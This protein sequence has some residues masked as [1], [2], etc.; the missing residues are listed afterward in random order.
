MDGVVERVAKRKRILAFGAAGLAGSAAAGFVA[1]S[2]LRAAWSR[3]AAPRQP[4]PKAHPMG[5]KVELSQNFTKPIN[6]DF[7]ELMVDMCND[8]ASRYSNARRRVF[9]PGVLAKTDEAVKR[10]LPSDLFDQ[11]LFVE[12]S[13]DDGWCFACV[14]RKQNHIWVYDSRGRGRLVSWISS[15]RGRNLF[16]G[17]QITTAIDGD[18]NPNK[19]D[20][21]GVHVCARMYEFAACESLGTVLLPWDETRAWIDDAAPSRIFDWLRGLPLWQPGIDI[22]PPPFELCVPE[23]LAYLPGSVI[24][25][26]IDTQLEKHSTEDISVYG[27][28]ALRGLYR[29]GFKSGRRSACVIRSNQ[30]WG[31][32]IIDNSNGAKLATWIGVNGLTVAE[33]KEWVTDLQNGLVPGNPGRQPRSESTA[34]EWTIEQDRDTTGLS[35]YGHTAT[36]VLVCAW[37]TNL[38]LGRRLDI[39]TKV[40]NRLNLNLLG[41]WFNWIKGRGRG[42]IPFTNASSNGS[43]SVI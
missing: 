27:P 24:Q 2:H 19:V 31:I 13:V 16:D 26:V 23:S 20:L 39:G 33:R 36:G 28:L 3:S 38:V 1:A 34:G 10:E 32:V 22:L 29:N 18:Y 42:E 30:R 4:R 7:I 35:G 17:I 21:S 41:N 25:T 37:I 5:R 12:G 11:A 15:E 6:R 40:D 43:T 8:Q 14:D 9:G